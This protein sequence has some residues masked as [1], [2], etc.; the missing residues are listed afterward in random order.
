MESEGQNLEDWLD[1]YP[2]DSAAAAGMHAEEMHAPGLGN[3]ADQ[4]LHEVRTFPFELP[5]L[6]SCCCMVWQPA[7][8]ASSCE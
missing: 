1:S 4:A 7:E 3:P 2:E 8:C 5:E 6:K